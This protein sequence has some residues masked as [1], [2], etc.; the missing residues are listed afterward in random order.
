MGTLFLVDLVHF[1]PQTAC[2][3]QLLSVVSG[4]AATR[5]EHACQT[6]CATKPH[7][8]HGHWILA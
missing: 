2:L 4:D 6:L 1:I 7:G 3:V 5:Q 8:M